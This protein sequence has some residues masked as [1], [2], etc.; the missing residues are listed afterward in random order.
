MIFLVGQNEKACTFYVVF[1][2]ICKYVLS[3]FKYA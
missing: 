2:I 3:I 1:N